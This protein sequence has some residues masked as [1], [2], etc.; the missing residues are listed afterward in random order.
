MFRKTFRK[1]YLPYFPG[2]ASLL[3]LEPLLGSAPAVRLQNLIS[4]PARVSTPAR[5]SA[6]PIR[7]QNLISAPAPPSSLPEDLDVEEAALVVDSD[8]ET[9]DL[10]DI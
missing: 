5:F 4:S 6:P 10:S 7:L 2:L 8:D 3:E 9:D 1:L